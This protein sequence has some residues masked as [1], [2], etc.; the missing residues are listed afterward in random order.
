MTGSKKELALQKILDTRLIP[1]FYHADADTCK[2]VVKACYEG[3]I[4]VFEFT[5]RGEKA[6]ENFT[7]LKDYVRQSFPD[8]L[9]GIGTIRDPATAHQYMAAKADFIVSPIVQPAIAQL[10]Q[11]QDLL[12]IPGC[13]TPTEI[14]LAERS[15]AKLVKLFP[16]NLLGP[17]YV[18]AIKA[19]FPKLLF[20]PTGGVE[21]TAESIRQ[22]LQAGVVALGMGSKL[23]PAD[24]LKTRG[25]PELK[26]KVE[27]ML[28][29]IEGV[30]R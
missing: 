25:F 16:G 26:E 28:G 21:P 24:I 11:E 8:M 9:L 6:L 30:S 20:M 5:N 22:W 13:M 18:N 3:G 15:G 29:I 19:L 23:I 10:C 17:E 2:S 7:L 1:V 27:L 12:W 14:D 4:R